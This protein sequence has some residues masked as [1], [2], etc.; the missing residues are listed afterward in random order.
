MSDIFEKASTVMGSTRVYNTVVTSTVSVKAS[1]KAISASRDSRIGIWPG[2]QATGNPVAIAAATDLEG[3]VT[4]T[5]QGYDFNDGPYT[6][7]FI[8]NN[9]TGNDSICATVVLV[10][11]QYLKSEVTT[12]IV[13]NQKNQDGKTYLTVQ[14][15]TP[16]GNTPNRS[17]DWIYL[18][19]GSQVVSPGQAVQHTP[20]PSNDS[21][22]SIV[23]VTDSPLTFGNDYI[24]EYNPGRSTTAISAYYTFKFGGR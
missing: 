9:N 6:V 10:N 24:I 14:Y 16:D 20:V 15:S 17:L 18:F 1:Y 4:L 21:R 5:V 8:V 13:T 12:L 7:G 3:E 2:F 11:G 23:I 19:N 22:G